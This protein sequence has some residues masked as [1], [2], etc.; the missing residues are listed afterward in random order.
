MAEV[1]LTTVWIHEAADTS[2]SITLDVSDLG[3]RTGGYG[4]VQRL[5]GGRLVAV[6]LE[7]DRSR[8]TITGELTTRSDVDTVRGWA[9]GTELMIRGPFGRVV[10]GIIEGDIAISEKGGTSTTTLVPRIRFTL[11][12]VTDSAEV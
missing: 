10:W 4:K 2:T 5:A 3:E 1:T 12:E 6:S 11:A 9:A 8:Y 7:G